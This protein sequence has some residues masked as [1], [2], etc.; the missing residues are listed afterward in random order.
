MSNVYL[1]QIMM[2]GGNFAPKGFAFCN[3]QLLS[4]QQNAALFSLLGTAYGGNGVQ[5][6]ALPNLQSNLPV[7]QGTGPGLST[8]PLGQPGGSPSVTLTTP[9][10]P[11]HNHFLVATGLT[12]TETAIGP[13]VLP[14]APTGSNMPTFYAPSGHDLPPVVQE[15]LDQSACSLTGGN[16]PHTNLMPSLCITFVIALQGV[17]PARN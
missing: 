6:F 13:G 1:G 11:Q 17:F 4:I 15:I 16:Q 3:G 10:I 8:Y 14:G 2:F 7:H 12:A 9:T 5:N